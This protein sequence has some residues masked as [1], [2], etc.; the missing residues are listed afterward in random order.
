MVTSRADGKKRDELKLHLADLGGS[1]GLVAGRLYNEVQ[2]KHP[3]NA[4]FTVQNEF[5]LFFVKVYQA[6]LVNLVQSFEPGTELIVLGQM[7]SF[8]NRRCR[9]HH[10]FIRAQEIF[11]LIEAPASLFAKIM[12]E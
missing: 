3:R 12:E 9:N 4:R 11:P 6:S 8:V 10:V 7:H 5:G 1:L 2:I